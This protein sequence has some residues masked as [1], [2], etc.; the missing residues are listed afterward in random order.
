MR[1]STRASTLIIA[2]IQRQRNQRDLTVIKRIIMLIG[3]L[4]ALRFPTIIFMI[5]AVMF[6]QT[7][8]L[9]YGIVGII[10]SA[11]LIFIGIATIY[12]TPPLRKLI[13]AHLVQQNNRVQAEP[14][15]MTQIGAPITMSDNVKSTQ[16][17]KRKAIISLKNNS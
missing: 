15:P 8:P 5:Y 13:H 6:G 10:T 14:I 7:Y 16:K 9:T 17:S 4:I 2:V 11:C 1:R 3:I 12:T